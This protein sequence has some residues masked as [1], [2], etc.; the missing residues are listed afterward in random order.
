[1]VTDAVTT[2]KELGVPDEAIRT[3]GWAVPRI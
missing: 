1:M 3:E 2:L